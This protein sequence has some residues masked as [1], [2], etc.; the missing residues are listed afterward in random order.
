[1]Q[2]PLHPQECKAVTVQSTGLGDPG[3]PVTRPAGLLPAP[4]P[5]RRHS[6]EGDTALPVRVA[7]AWAGSAGYS[8]AHG[9]AAP[10]T[11]EQARLSDSQ[12]RME[13]RQRPAKNRSRKSSKEADIHCA[14]QLTGPAGEASL[15]ETNLSLGKKLTRA[16]IKMRAEWWHV[17]G[18]R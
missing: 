8:R 16:P 10:G 2:S 4:K 1:M 9:C 13:S 3:C 12:N 7:R 15:M 11:G 17:G 18:H 6:Q 5:P 14:T